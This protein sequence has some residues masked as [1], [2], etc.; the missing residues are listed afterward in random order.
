MDRRD[1]LKTTGAAAVAAGTAAGTPATADDADGIA[2]PAAPAILSGVQ[3]LTLAST[4]PTDLAGAGA[5][6]LARRLEAATG[7]RFRIEVRHGSGDADL[8][9]GSAHHSAHAAFAFF[10]GLPFAQALDAAAMQTWLGAGGGQMLWD[11]LAAAHGFKPLVAGHTGESAGVWAAARLER[12]S[13]L[14]GLRIAVTGIAGDVLATFGATPVEISPQ[15]L[16]AALADGRIAAAEWLGPLAAV[17]PDLQPLTQRL[18]QPGFHSTGALLALGIRRQ[19]WERFSAADQAIFEACAAQEYHLSLTDAQ[20]HALIARQVELP[21]K[22]PV[23]LAFPAEMAS[24]LEAAT[25]D[26]VVR[27][28]EFDAMARHIHDSYQAFRA[29]L[30]EPRTA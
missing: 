19:L 22:W 29:M 1:F 15:E 20:A 17:A 5:E 25:R 9:F 6:R 3:D 12:V 8:G 26:A 18:Y 16:K 28:A 30:G 14:A 21:E 23:R 7:G 4:S 13:D 27:L 11:E 2:R 10:A 24:A